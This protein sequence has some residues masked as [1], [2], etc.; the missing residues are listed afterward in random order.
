M[1]DK[2]KN[3]TLFIV[4]LAAMMAGG[5]FYL[6]VFFAAS[7]ALEEIGKPNDLLAFAIT[8]AAVPM[9]FIAIVVG[10][11]GARHEDED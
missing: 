1:D 9:L 8:V 4:S 11:K 3:M 10:L 2:R 5:T 7:M 6:I